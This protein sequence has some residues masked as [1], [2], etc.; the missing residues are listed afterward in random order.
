MS[1]VELLAKNGA[2]VNHRD[3]YG[4]T[5]VFIA[6]EN[7]KNYWIRFPHSKAWLKQFALSDQ[8]KIVEKLAR[9][10]ADVNLKNGSGQYALHA[11]IKSSTH[12][13]NAINSKIVPL[14]SKF[15][16]FTIF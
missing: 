3:N 10:R 9:N 15:T 7:G 1:I 13:W 2:D 8:E 5:P 11:A 6:V 12:T 16:D 14:S 4:F